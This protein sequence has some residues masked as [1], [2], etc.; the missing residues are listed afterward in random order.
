MG[1]KMGFAEASE[2]I[3][4]DLGSH[5]LHFIFFVIANGSNKLECSSLASFSSLT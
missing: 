4:C 2:S 1:I 5:S 3:V